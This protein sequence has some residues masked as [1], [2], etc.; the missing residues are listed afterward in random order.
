MGFALSTND[1]TTSVH[2]LTQKRK[3]YKEVSI[4]D[5]KYKA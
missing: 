3:G 2:I 1:I 5:C 4:V